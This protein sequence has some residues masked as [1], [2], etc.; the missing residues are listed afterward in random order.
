MR[1][2]LAMLSTRYYRVDSIELQF[3]TT[4]CFGSYLTDRVRRKAKFSC[5]DTLNM[6]TCIQYT[7]LNTPT[8]TLADQVRS[9]IADEVSLVNLKASENV[10]SNSLSTVKM[11]GTRLEIRNIRKF[12]F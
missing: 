12:T 9:S 10:K 6:M 5:E 2:N 4:H 11:I 1:L 3:S 8:I 7:V